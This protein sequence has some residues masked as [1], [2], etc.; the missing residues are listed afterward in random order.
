MSALLVV[1][2]LVSGCSTVNQATFGPTE[3]VSA[4]RIAELNGQ[5]RE[6]PSLEATLEEYRAMRASLAE[7]IEAIAPG[8]RFH[9][10][11]DPKDHY[12]DHR[13]SCS[14]EWLNT[15]GLSVDLAMWVSDV[16][17]GEEAWPKAVAIVRT[18]ARDRGI[19]HESAVKSV[20]GDREVRFSNSRNA[21]I[22]LSSLK[23]AVLSVRTPCRL[24]EGPAVPTPP[25][26]QPRSP[27]T[28]ES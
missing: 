15:E 11:M 8:V 19:V 10:T 9:S 20:P 27:V 14:G 22:D 16:P 5:L 1:G 18:A 25:A 3:E 6:L 7:H 24:P 17:I 23:A 2:V 12:P 21:T 13:R 4:E 28:G 26:S